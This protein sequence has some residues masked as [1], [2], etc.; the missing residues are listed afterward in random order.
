[1]PV[2]SV[3]LAT[4]RRHSQLVWLHDP[5]GLPPPAP[6][7]TPPAAFNASTPL[8]VTLGSR[9]T[10]WH[11]DEAEAWL[12]FWKND[13]GGVMALRTALQKSEPSAPVFSWSDDQVIAK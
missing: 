7:S 12:R 6:L 3:P 9:R 13:V 2:M 10:F 8:D 11:A 1:M 5:M 4:L